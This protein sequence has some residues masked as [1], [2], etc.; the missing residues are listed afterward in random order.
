MVL[1]AD[2]AKML[3]YIVLRDCPAACNNERIRLSIGQIQG[4]VIMEIH[5]CEFGFIK[6][7][8]TYAQNCHQ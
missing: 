8:D 7:Y 1:L 3:V 6:S 5:H 4:I 2:G